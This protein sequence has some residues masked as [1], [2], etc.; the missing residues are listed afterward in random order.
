MKP[1][2]LLVPGA[3]IPSWSVEYLGSY[4]RKQGY[5]T[6]RISYPSVRGGADVGIDLLH[7]AILTLPPNKPICILAH[8]LGGLLAYEAL[9]RFF[10]VRAMIQPV[11][12]VCIGSPFGGSAIARKANTLPWPLHLLVKNTIYILT[13][14]V[15]YDRDVKAEIGAIT[16]IKSSGGWNMILR[17]LPKSIPHDG[18]ISYGETHFEGVKEYIDLNLGHEQMLFNKDVARLAIS[19]F[20]TGSFKA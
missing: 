14:G 16:G 13:S 7:K 5:E 6:K 11:R 9:R 15:W 3:I 12:L 17:A 20:E 10:R 2:V 1:I 8:S 4:L 18:C 19:F